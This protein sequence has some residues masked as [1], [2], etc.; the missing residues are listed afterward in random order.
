MS[1]QTQP[2]SRPSSAPEQVPDTDKGR[3]AGRTI[4]ASVIAGAVAAL[5]LA[6]V[7]FPGGT[8]ARITGS[9][10]LG[11]GFGWALMAALTT[12]RTR[13]PQRWAVV[14]AVA[15]GATGAALVVFNPGNQTLTALNWVWP[16]LMVALTAWMFLQ[17]RRS[18]TGKARWVLTPVLVV[19]VLASIGGT[20]ANIAGTSDQARRRCPGEAVRRRRTPAPPGLP[21]PRFSDRRALQ[22]AR[23]SLRWLGQDHRSGGRDHPGMRL[24]PCRTG[25]E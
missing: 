23:W 22:R 14:P 6:L 2:T 11:F 21:R 3:P 9:L 19:L 16:P 18:V 4:V 15:M 7:V 12:R 8:E 20:Y 5:V 13:Q 17:M 25:L 10:V 24:R 1:T